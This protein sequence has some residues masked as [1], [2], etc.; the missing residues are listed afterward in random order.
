M[1]IQS[2]S[3]RFSRFSIFEKFPP[4]TAELRIGPIRLVSRLL[5]VTDPL[6]GLASEA[7]FGRHLRRNAKLRLFRMLKLI[8][9]TVKAESAPP[10]AFRQIGERLRSLSWMRRL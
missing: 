4:K 2:W 3:P 7:K 9:D 1:T 10:M 8:N 6:E 5:G